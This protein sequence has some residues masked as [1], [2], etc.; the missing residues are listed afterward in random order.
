MYYAVSNSQSYRAEERVM[1]NPHVAPNVALSAFLSAH[2]DEM[3]RPAIV[4]FKQLILEAQKR[5]V[6]K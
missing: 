5:W 6:L 4:A 3:R 2:R 1:V